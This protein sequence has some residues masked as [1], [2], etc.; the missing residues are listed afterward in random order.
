[1]LH[2]KLEKYSGVAHAILAGDKLLL[3]TVEGEL[4]LTAA[5]PEKYIELGRAKVT[6]GV[7]RALPALSN[8]KIYF[9]TN[10]GGAGELVC[11]QLAD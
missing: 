10:A 5:S 2:G 1:M 11:L 6:K 3:L 7:T 9:R 4:V 8:G